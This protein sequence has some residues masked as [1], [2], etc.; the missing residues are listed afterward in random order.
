MPA[1]LRV[2]NPVACIYIYANSRI[3]RDI[4]AGPF[5]IARIEFW[6]P[7]KTYQISIENFQQLVNAQKFAS[8]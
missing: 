8:A 5:L 1:G 6:L 7:K 4:A 3:S 2:G